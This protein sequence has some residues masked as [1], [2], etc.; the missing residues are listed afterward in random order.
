VLPA[1]VGFE[2]LFVRYAEL[3]RTERGP[4]AFDRLGRETGA[5]EVVGPP[6]AVSDPL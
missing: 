5:L 6:L 2:Q 3:S 1:A 4:A